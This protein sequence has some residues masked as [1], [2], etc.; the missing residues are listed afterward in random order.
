MSERIAPHIRT[1][2][3]AWQMTLDVL[4]AGLVLC[5][6]SAVNYGPRPLLLVLFSML[7]AIAAE[8]VCTLCR[9]RSLRVLLDGSA[10]VTGM[11]VG[12]AM[13]PMTDHWVPMLGSA[14]AIVVVK[15]PF[16][17]Y[18][19]NVFDPA[20][21]GIA[22]VSFCFPPRV[23]TYPVPSALTRLPLLAG[24]TA[25]QVAESSLAAQLRVDRLVLFRPEFGARR[26]PAEAFV[27]RNLCFC[28]SEILIFD[29]ADAASLKETDALCHGLC[30]AQI[31][32][33]PGE[34]DDA[35]TAARFLLAEDA[36]SAF[37]PE[38]GAAT[39]C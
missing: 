35:Q 15:A 6:F 4:I 12:L 36:R 14:F 20:A 39:L 17:G 27:R 9:R 38:R 18:G 37:P 13:S 7:S 3:R 10:A 29:G 8:A 16:G 21:A 25:G 5:I 23:F 26:S 34:N 31:W 11:L 19:R 2:A 32:R 30:S 33:V 28:V 24:S 1:D 22:V